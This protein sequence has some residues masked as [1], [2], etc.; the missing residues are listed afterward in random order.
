MLVGLSRIE[1]W[2]SARVL[3]TSISI[4]EGWKSA[5][6]ETRKIIVGLLH[7]PF[8]LSFF[9]TQRERYARWH[10]CASAG[11]SLLF[12]DPLQAGVE[13]ARKFLVGNNSIWFDDA[14]ECVCLRF[15]CVFH[16]CVTIASEPAKLSVERKDPIKHYIRQLRS[17]RRIRMYA[18]CASY[19]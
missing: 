14:N 9:W 5:V 3:Y 17:V 11:F 7:R 4:R 13:N 1:D 16:D 6:E 12:H 2:T 10:Y 8:S 18:A 19:L 15:A